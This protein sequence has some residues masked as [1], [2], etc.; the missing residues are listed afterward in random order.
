MHVRALCI[1]EQH[2]SE[3]H[4]RFINQLRN[5]ERP[6]P[7]AITI[8]SLSILRDCSKLHE[9]LEQQSCENTVNINSGLVIETKNAVSRASSQICAL[10]LGVKKN[11][12]ELIAGLCPARDSEK[13]LIAMH[14]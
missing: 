8:D 12:H 13:L 5:T 14:Q 1:S 7:D 3:N 4:T 2:W 11:Q 10:R 6:V 9:S